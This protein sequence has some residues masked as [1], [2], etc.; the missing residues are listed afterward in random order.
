MI[1]SPSETDPSL[2]SLEEWRTRMRRFDGRGMMLRA[3]NAAVRALQAHPDDRWLKHR[4]VLARVHSGATETAGG[5]RRAG[6]D[7][8]ARNSGQIRYLSCYDYRI[9]TASWEP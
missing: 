1:D 4:A 6:G 5:A 7:R 2:A 8:E 3:Y 9:E